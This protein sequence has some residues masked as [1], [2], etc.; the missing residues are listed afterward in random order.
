MGELDSPSSP[1]A[2]AGEDLPDAM[3]V[4]IKA[5]LVP[6]ER[7]LW[8][9]QPV[10]PVVARRTVAWVAWLVGSAAVVAGGV[11]V[12]VVLRSEGAD[13]GIGIAVMVIGFLATGIWIIAMAMSLGERWADRRVRAGILYALTERRAIRWA[14]SRYLRGVQVTSIPARTIGA[15]D[16][17]ELDDGTGSVWFTGNVPNWAFRG[18]E[19]IAGA[20]CVE[21]L[22]REILVDPGF[23]H[24]D[25]LAEFD[26]H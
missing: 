15:L 10:R 26:T 11:L 9:G 23:R 17:D 22:A 20:R 19:G 14:P 2:L 25:D 8:V 5:E 1:S 12:R 3:R 18:F 13:E 21:I 24:H 4:R 7:M 6:G 16:R